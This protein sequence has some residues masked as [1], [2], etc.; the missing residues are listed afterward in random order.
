MP[1]RD[2]AVERL[3]D[4]CAAM[5]G[6]RRVFIYPRLAARNVNR[7]LALDFKPPPPGEALSA[8]TNATFVARN[9]HK[10]VKAADKGKKIR[11]R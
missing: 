8:E 1:G 7:S 5:V 3:I 9:A 10:A 2:G 11:T 4:N 6:A